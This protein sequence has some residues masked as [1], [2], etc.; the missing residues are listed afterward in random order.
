GQANYAT[1]NVFLDALA[2]HR[3]TT[4]LPATSL[5]WGLWAGT[6]MGAQLDDAALARMARLGLEPL[7]TEQNLRLLDLAASGDAPAVVAV[8]LELRALQALGDELPHLLRGLVRTP[9]RRTAASGP[10]AVEVS[11]GGQL[12][13]LS[14]SERDDLLLDLVRTQIA[15][16]LGHD[17][18]EAIEPGRAFSDI[19]FD[20]LSSV[21]LRNRLNSTT[22]LRLSATLVFDYPTPRALAKHIAGKLLDV[23]E[24]A[25]AKAGAVLAPLTD[26]PVVIVGMAC[27]YPGGVTSPEELWQLVAEGTDAI[28]GFP[29]DRGWPEDLYDPEPGTA[30]KTYSREGGFL[31]DAAEFDPAFFD[32]SPR[33]ATAMDPQQRLLLETS[34]ETFE[35]AGI[36][37]VAMRG[38]RTGV[39]AGVMYHDWGTRLGEV[40]EEIA[41]YLGNGSLASVVSGRVAYALGLE[42]PAVTVDTACS[43]SLVALHMAAQALRSGECSLALAGG[44]TV[45]S[46]PDTFIDMSRQRG[47]AADGRCK[48]FA[49]AADGTG[50]SEGAG[51][52]LL[53]R[54]SDAQRNGHRVLGVVRGSAINQDGASNGLTAPNGPSQQRV[55]QQALN[56]AGLASSEVD[57]VE[58]HGTGTTLGDPI[59]AQALLATYGQGR[60]EGRPLWLGS[61]KSNMGHTQAAAGVAGIIKMVMAMRHGILPRTMHVD[62]PSPKVDWESGAVELLTEQQPWPT[63]DRRRRAGISSFGIS[64]TNAHVIIEQAPEEPEPVTASEPAAPVGTLLPFLISARTPEAMR[65]QAGRLRT[66][67]DGEPAAGLAIVARSLATRR[68]AL[69]HRAVVLSADRDDLISGLTALADGRAALSDSARDGKLAFVFTGQGAQRL[70]MGSELY[71]AFPVF[72]RALD[73]VVA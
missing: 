70:G 29:A 65:A 45:M 23:R 3:R 28:A 7:T 62:E 56:S 21:E 6:G 40:P 64:G 14:E 47:L 36:D 11:L 50:W 25:V 66:F 32:I 27:R 20:S 68:P 16:V 61:I 5:D 2:V 63:V 49:G 59:E 35:R 15:E 44:V 69:E 53:E 54:L 39:F 67:L 46:T 43:S 24:E 12:A 52:L 10:V 9:A 57:A 58:G 41:G 51:L 38:S 31:Y 19:G 1:A 4:G 73:A 13:A 33:E 55:I 8:R 34:W 48:S 42:G 18:A 26:D 22:G 30:G 37:P 72:A 71:D 60:E 17:G